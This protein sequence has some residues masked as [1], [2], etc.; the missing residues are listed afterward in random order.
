MEKW[1]AIVVIAATSV[2][3]GVESTG[4]ERQHER[5]APGTGAPPNSDDPSDEEPGEGPGWEVA[6]P[7]SITPSRSMT[8]WASYEN[9]HYSFQAPR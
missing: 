9:G 7:R 3:C 6:P 1:I 4:T 2:G 8:D 5:A